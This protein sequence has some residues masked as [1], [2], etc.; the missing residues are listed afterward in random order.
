M[1]NIKLV[2]QLILFAT[3]LLL[4]SKV[5]AASITLAPNKSTATVGEEL[6]ISM[7]LSGASLA[8]LNVK[9]TV[10]TSKVEYISSSAPNNTNFNNGRI[11]Y[12][13]TD[14]SGGSN[15]KTDGT[16]VTFRLRAKTAG[17]ASFSISGKFYDTNENS[18]NLGL[19]GTS[20]T[21]KE[22]QVVT[23][24]TTNETPDDTINDNNSE[25]TT[26]EVPDD[27]IA[28]EPPQV[29][30]PPQVQPPQV[31]EPPQNEEENQPTVDNNQNT[32]NNNNQ[33]SSNAYLSSL[34]INVEGISPR[35]NKN[36]TKYYLT[37]DNT[38]DS[39]K[40]TAIPEDKNAKI[41][42]LGNTN[43]ELGSNTITIQVTA[44]NKTLQRNYLIEVTKTDDPNNANT[45]LENL[46]I[47]NVTLTPE[48]RGDVLE[49]SA[50]VGSDIE[51]LNILA[52]PE[53]EGA[54]V[55][56][57]GGDKLIFGNNVITITVT[58][59]NG[60]SIKNY[61]VNIYRKTESEETEE[62]RQLIEENN[63]IEENIVNNSANNNIENEDKNT[64]LKIFFV[65]LLILII[66]I[67]VYII[68]KN[69]KKK[70]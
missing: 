52:V 42:I 12:T 47:E 26:P 34:Q 24:P 50:S 64:F 39:I 63:N 45:N 70:G 27:G 29:E 7:N 31:E 69:R 2:L 9:I 41:D 33:L 1:K 10:D 14:T 67:I 62:Q 20:V 60:T 56:I 37:V 16:I 30:Q 36:T 17:T 48:F 19:N 4:C 68:W 32:G 46:A 58:A 5:E 44:E 59:K 8:S 40:V 35:F 65:V 15:P 49:Y 21:I 54:N 25:T 28:N 6:T 55:N 38:I 66:A 11:L 23:P 53:I 3:I 43:L 18:L 57:T 61:N 22:K 51:T 13:W